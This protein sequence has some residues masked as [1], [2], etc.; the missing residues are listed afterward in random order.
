[1]SCPS[2]AK[3]FHSQSQIINSLSVQFEKLISIK[4]KANGCSYKWFV[5][6]PVFSFFVFFFWLIFISRLLPLFLLGHLHAE[7][8]WML[9][10]WCLCAYWRVSVAPCHPSHDKDKTLR[11]QE[12][13]FAIINRESDLCLCSRGAHCRWFERMSRSWNRWL[14]TVCWK[15]HENKQTISQC[16]TESTTGHPEIRR[17]G[18]CFVCFDHIHSRKSQL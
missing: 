8:F 1:M 3:S 7:P 16:G 14:S 13:I 18:I 15:S 17:L 9:H 2:Q 12:R 10:E 4:T 6:Q 11:L 5:F